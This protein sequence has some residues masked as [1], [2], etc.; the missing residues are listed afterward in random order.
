MIAVGVILLFIVGVFAFLWN[1]FFSPLFSPADTHTVPNLVGKTL[2]EVYADDEIMAEF[3]IET[4]DTVSDDNIDAGEIMDQSPQ[5]GTTLHG[6]RPTITVTISGGPDTGK[7]M[8][9]ELSG[10]ELRQAEDQLNALSKS[11]SLRLIIQ[12]KE[13]SSESINEGYVVRTEPASGSELEEG[14][15]VT[16][17]KSTGPEKLPTTVPDLFNKTVEEA[18]KM[19]SEAKLQLGEPKEVPSDT[20]EK[21]FIIFQDIRAGQEVEEDTVINVQVSTG[22]LNPDVSDSPALPSDSGNTGTPGSG[23]PSQ[24]VGPTMGDATVTVNLSGYEGDVQVRIMVGGTKAY[25]KI[26]NANEGNANVVISGT[27]TQHVEVY[28]NEKLVDSYDQAFTE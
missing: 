11:E 24:N 13:E 9:P 25:D 14:Q 21:G 7:P 18:Q 26:L 3:K 8:M 6:E 10:K 27:G 22:P 1:S 19:L 20:V 16:I 12:V 5:K 15:T 23:E 2:D 28:C 17:F 4:G